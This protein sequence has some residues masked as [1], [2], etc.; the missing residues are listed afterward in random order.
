MLIIEVFLTTININ[1]KIFK[2][3]LYDKNNIEKK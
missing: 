1:I 2:K 3:K